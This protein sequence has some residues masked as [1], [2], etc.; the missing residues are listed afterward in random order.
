[1]WPRRTRSA[2]ARGFALDALTLAV[3]QRGSSRAR[4]E[5]LAQRNRDAP[6]VLHLPARGVRQ[7]ELRLQR[8]RLRRVQLAQHVGREPRLVRVAMHDAVLLPPEA[9]AGAPPG[10]GARGAP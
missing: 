5:R 7:E 10:P 4:G 1:M 9:V 8:R 6:D 2:D 3:R